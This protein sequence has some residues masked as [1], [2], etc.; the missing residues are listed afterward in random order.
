[1]LAGVAG[2]GG[3]EERVKQG[4]F[5]IGE[6][7]EVGWGLYTRSLSHP[8]APL[9]CSVPK[10]SL[11]EPP[12]HYR[13][14]AYHL[15]RVSATPVASRPLGSRSAAGSRCGGRAGDRARRPWSPVRS[16]VAARSR[17]SVSPYR[18]RVARLAVWSNATSS[19]SGAISHA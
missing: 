9:R 15:P 19:C 14:V 17:A 13:R 18:Q 5:G 1:M 6:I 4:P 12:F 10:Q 3:W 16:R 7:G 8:A 11:S 2:R